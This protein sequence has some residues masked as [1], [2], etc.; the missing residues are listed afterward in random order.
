MSS[1]AM[2]PGAMDLP[3]VPEFEFPDRLRKARMAYAQVTQTRITQKQFAELI[4]VPEKAYENW[5]SGYNRPEDIVAV[6]EAIETVTRIPAS[7]MLT[8][9][10]EGAAMRLSREHEV[11]GHEAF[12]GSD[13]EALCDV[14]DR[15]RAADPNYTERIIGA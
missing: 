12:S 13:M 15:V 10:Y 5:E 14:A 7:W 11:A 8:G 2:V 1:P 6:S 3:I 9:R 4:G